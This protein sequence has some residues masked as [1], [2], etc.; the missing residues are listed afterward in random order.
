VTIIFDAYRFTRRASFFCEYNVNLSIA[1]QL[2]YSP[3]MTDSFLRNIYFHFISICEE[4]YLT[5][6]KSYDILIPRCSD[7]KREMKENQS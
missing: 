6:A 5:P 7:L 3:P 4:I 2:F 1:L